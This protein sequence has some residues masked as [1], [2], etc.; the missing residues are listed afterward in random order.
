M[1]SMRLTLAYLVYQ[2]ADWETVV[3]IVRAVWRVDT[4]DICV[5]AVSCS[6][7]SWGIA[8]TST[9]PTASN[10]TEATYRTVVHVDA[11]ATD[12][13]NLLVGFGYKRMHNRCRERISS[14]V[15]FW[16]SL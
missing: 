9:R 4:R 14:I 12:E 7:G 2:T 15:R 11:P 10:N 16:H 13:V 5:E 1:W 6:W 3:T 8:Y